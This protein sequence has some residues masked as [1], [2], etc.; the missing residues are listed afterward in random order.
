M[1]IKKDK[2]IDKILSEFDEASKLTLKQIE[3]LIKVISTKDTG[4]P[5]DILKQIKKNEKKL[6]VF[7]LKISEKIINVMVLYG[8]VASELRNLMACYRMII[9][10]ERIGDLVIKASDSLKKLNDKRLLL[11][12]LE[13]ITKMSNLAFEMVSKATLSFTNNEKEEAIW[14]IQNDLVVG[15]LNR[16]ITRNSI[17]AEEVIEEMQKALAD[18]SETRN[19]ISTIERIADHATHIAE[20]SIFASVGKDIRHKSGFSIKN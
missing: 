17:L 16:H 12:N 11:L 8:P 6:D 19:I 3:L 14:V 9:S 4:I 2:A 15:K 10:L 5:T 7:E 20:A 18:Y 13:D 1:S